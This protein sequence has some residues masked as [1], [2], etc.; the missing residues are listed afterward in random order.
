[1]GPTATDR[2]IKLVVEDVRTTRTFA[3]RRIVLSQLQDDGSERSSLA[4]TLDFMIS[5]PTS[6]LKFHL[7]MPLV[8]PPAEISPYLEALDARVAAKTMHPKINSTFKTLFGL[9][10]RFLE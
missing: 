4:V 7:P 5:S 2:H 9:M 6:F 1:M 3:T 10:F 8:T